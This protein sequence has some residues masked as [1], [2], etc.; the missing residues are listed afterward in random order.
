VK[1]CTK[2]KKEYLATLKYFPPNKQHK[3]KLHSQCRECGRKAQREYRKT[4]K[5]RLSHNKNDKK[6][7]QSEKGKATRNKACKK[8]RESKHGKTVCMQRHLNYTFGITIKN[9]NQLFQQQSGCC[10]I[11]GIHQSK[12]IRRLCVDHDHDTNKI[13]GLLC[14]TCNQGIGYLKSDPKILQNAIK[15]LEIARRLI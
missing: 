11:C 1:T 3:D 9:Y 8:Y 6:Y 13:R 5:G 14:N 15:Y 7:Q 10:A 2:C 12:L 4:E